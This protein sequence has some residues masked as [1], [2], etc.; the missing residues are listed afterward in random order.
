MGVQRG[1][2]EVDAD[3]VALGSSFADTVRPVVQ[4]AEEV[5][6][7]DCRTLLQVAGI[8]WNVVAPFH[9]VHSFAVQD[10]VVVAEGYVKQVVEACSHS[11][12][13]HY[14]H[15]LSLVQVLPSDYA[16][17][18][19]SRGNCTAVQ[20]LVEGIADMVAE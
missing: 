13:I 3:M 12:D 2:D 5:D 4:M 14:I 15:A 11:G 20:D 16:A 10:V 18:L 1:T 6:L 9:L 17:G 7:G 19:E 8:D